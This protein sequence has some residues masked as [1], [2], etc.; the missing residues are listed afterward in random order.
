MA[1]I[2]GIW[3]SGAQPAQYAGSFESI[4][5][6]TVG[7]GGSSTITFS[8]IPSTYSH[9]QLRG[10]VRNTQTGTS[11]NQM[12]MKF[13]SSGTS[14]YALH[15]MYGDGSSAAASVDSASSAAYPVYVLNDGSLS[16]A[17]AVFVMDILDYQNT[18]KYKTVR[19]LSGYDTN[20]AGVV[21][22]RSNLWQ[23]TNAISQI[24]LQIA[25]GSYNFVQYSQI[26]L[27]GI[28]GS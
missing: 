18:N 9:L 19:T 6:V 3:A 7:S 22:L 16:S 21:V 17:F 11:G 13:N 8:S 12:T 14:Y 20:G 26:A 4:A 2:L 5:T 25:A 23:N 10:I 24:D 1:P 15:Q 28:K 27:Y